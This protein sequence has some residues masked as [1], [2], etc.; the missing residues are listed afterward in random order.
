MRFCYLLCIAAPIELLLG[1]VVPINDIFDIVSQGLDLAKPVAQVGPVASEGVI[2]RIFQQG[3]QVHKGI[4]DALQIVA[5]IAAQ[6]HLALRDP[7]DVVD[8][9]GDLAHRRGHKHLGANHGCRGG[10]G[11]DR[12]KEESNPVVICEIGEREERR[13][14]EAKRSLL[15]TTDTRRLA[16]AHWGVS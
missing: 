7:H 12:R 3:F 13:Y 5:E 10:W 15:L 2:L 9:P 6:L 16:I 8:L 1:R 4:L 11:P 14:G